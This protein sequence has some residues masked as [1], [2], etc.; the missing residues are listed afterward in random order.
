[1]DQKKLNYTKNT[2]EHLLECNYHYLELGCPGCICV[3]KIS[4][5]EA[6]I[7]RSLDYY[8]LS[9]QEQWQQDKLLG[10]L[11]WDGTEE[12]LKEHEIVF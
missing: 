2:Q 3:K 6:K 9:S 5:L 11:D 4:D 12:W 10:I 1:M 8:N 7:G